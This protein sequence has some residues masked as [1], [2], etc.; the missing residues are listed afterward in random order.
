LL[1]N[2]ACVC[3]KPYCHCH[4]HGGHNTSECHTHS[5]TKERQGPLKKNPQGRNR[6][7]G[8]EKAHNTTDGV[9]EDSDVDI[10]SHN[11]K[12]EICLMTSLVNFLDYTQQLLY[13][14]WEFPQD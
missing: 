1:E 14:S 6:K 12:F 9:D 11:V 8:N 10:D 2:A 4:K 5:D 3:G 7:K 13:S